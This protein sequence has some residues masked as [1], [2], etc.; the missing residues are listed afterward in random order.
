[1]VRILL[2]MNSP[3][4]DTI[5]SQCIYHTILEQCSLIRFILHI[6]NIHERI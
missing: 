4:S 6:Y 5:I 3:I 2:K 1:M